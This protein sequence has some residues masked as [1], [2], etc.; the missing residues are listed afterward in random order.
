MSQLNAA[1]MSYDSTYEVQR[2]NNFRVILDLSDITGANSRTRN[3]NISSGEIIE[4]AIDTFTVPS[5]T[6]SGQDLEYGNSIVKYAGKAEVDEASVTVKDF[7]EP[8]VE[9]ILYAWRNKVYN[10]VTGKVGWAVNYKKKAKVVMYGPNGEGKRTW[11][12]EGVWPSQVELGDFD[13]GGGEKRQLTMNLVVDNV[14]PSR[15]DFNVTYY[16]TDER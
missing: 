1:F 4:L 7:I 16:G 6:N 14:Y 2:T 15:E 3:S 5:I 12:L 13:Y 11:N 9:G 8:D 10:P